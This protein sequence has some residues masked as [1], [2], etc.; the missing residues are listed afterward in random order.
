MIDMSDVVATVMTL[1]LFFVMFWGL[2]KL[3]ERDRHL[4]SERTRWL[5]CGSLALAGILWAILGA[6]GS[7]W[8]FALLL[9]A[10]LFVMI[11]RRTRD[12]HVTGPRDGGTG[13]YGG[14]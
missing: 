1:A 4:L 7:A 5:L 11:L 6:A 13:L 10:P 14:P 12:A 9:T 3:D 8:A 2:D